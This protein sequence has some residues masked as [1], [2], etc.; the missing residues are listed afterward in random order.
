MRMRAHIYN[1]KYHGLEIPSA[2]KQKNVTQMCFVQIACDENN[3]I[4]TLKLS[5]YPYLTLHVIPKP[6][7]RRKLILEIKSS[8]LG[9]LNGFSPRYRG[10]ADTPQLFRSLNFMIF[11]H[12]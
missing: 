7:L 9:D 3:K 10:T 12:G 1:T 5:N 8:S 4:K 11:V 6:R 2:T